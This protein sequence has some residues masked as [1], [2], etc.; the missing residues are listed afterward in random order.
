MVFVIPKNNEIENSI[1]KTRKDKGVKCGIV[2]PKTKPIFDINKFQW[3]VLYIDGYA[4][5]NGR[6]I[7][8]DFED[9]LEG[10]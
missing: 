6:F 8:Y 3:I 5:V 2:Q 1:I 10:L 9:E 7:D 4:K